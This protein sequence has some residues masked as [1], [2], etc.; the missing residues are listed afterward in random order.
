[1][2]GAKPVL[3][4]IDPQTFNIDPKEIEKN[5]KKTKAILIVHLAGLPCDMKSIL[6]IVK[7]YKLKLIED[8]AHAIGG[9]HYNQHVVIW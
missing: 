7:K 1:M 5:N 2:S 4:D 6:H 8:C 9:Q 3:A